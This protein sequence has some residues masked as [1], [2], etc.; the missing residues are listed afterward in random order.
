LIRHIIIAKIEE[1][2]KGFIAVESKIKNTDSIK[3][4][5]KKEIL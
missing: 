4:I 1:I 3:K 2:K 5:L